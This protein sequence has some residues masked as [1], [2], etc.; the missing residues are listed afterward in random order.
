MN[1]ENKTQAFTLLLIRIWLG[2]RA[3]ISGIEKFS[4]TVSSES[5]V[6]IDGR[7]NTYGLTESSAV[8]TY[9]IEYYNGIPAPLKAKFLS[10]PLLPDFLVSLFDAILGPSLILIGITT[11]LGIL[12]R[13]SLFA[14][15]FIFTLLT[16]GL[17]LIKQ[18]SGVAWLGTHILLIAYALMHA[19][20]DKIA[21]VGKKW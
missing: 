17:I 5:E 7:V 12:P 2:M 15:G 16:V 1:K 19:E 10:Q 4:G 8:K 14:L 3:L 13:I 6:T 18:D 20:K 21:L 11:I 9:G